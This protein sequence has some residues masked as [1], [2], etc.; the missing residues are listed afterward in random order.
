MKTSSDVINLASADEI[1]PLLTKQ[2]RMKIHGLVLT[3][4]ILRL[5]MYRMVC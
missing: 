2:R 3:P 1:E 4:W 5:S